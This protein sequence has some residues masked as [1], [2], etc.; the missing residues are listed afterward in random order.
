[1][2]PDTTTVDA[3]VTNVDSDEGIAIYSDD[4]INDLRTR[5][6]DIQAGFIDEPRGALERANALVDEAITK[7]AEGF[8]RTREN[9]YHQWKRDGTVST[10]DMR[11][12]LRRYRSFFNRLLNT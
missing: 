8:A 4:Q 11:Q 6:N 9:L 12:A 2:T 5:W 3:P 1:M 10:E 7:L